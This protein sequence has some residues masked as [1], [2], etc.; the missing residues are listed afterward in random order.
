MISLIDARLWRVVFVFVFF[1]GTTRALKFKVR[2]APSDVG[3]FHLSSDFCIKNL[4]TPRCF[5]FQ[6]AV[7][8]EADNPVMP[9]KSQFV[10]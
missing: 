9:I 6:E 1:I 7:G 8:A 4:T 2:P 5:I 10:Q 3:R